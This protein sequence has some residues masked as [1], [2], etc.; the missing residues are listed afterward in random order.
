[1]STIRGPCR[2]CPADSA[3]VTWTPCVP[4]CFMPV[5]RGWGKA[6]RRAGFVFFPHFAPPELTCAFVVQETMTTMFGLVAVEECGVQWG[7]VE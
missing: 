6:A 7:A 1:M 5:E 3:F 2:E 4:L